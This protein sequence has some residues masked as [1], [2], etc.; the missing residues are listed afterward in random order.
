MPEFEIGNDFWRLSNSSYARTKRCI[1]SIKASDRKVFCQKQKMIVLLHRV[2]KGRNVQM[3][4]QKWFFDT[5]QLIYR[6]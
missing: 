5:F 3:G 6:P 4:N 2:C 1:S